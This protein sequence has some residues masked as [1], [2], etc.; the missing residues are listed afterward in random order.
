MH[1]FQD[2]RR[3]APTGTEADIHSQRRK[4]RALAA[5]R[6]AVVVGL[7]SLALAIALFA[8]AVPARAIV[9]NVRGHGYGITP[10]NGAAEA[11][12]VAAYRAEQAAAGHA[13]ARGFDE[14][15][16]GGSPLESKGGPVMHSA[17]THVIY[18]DPPTSQFTPT[19]RGI[20]D[21]FFTNVADDSGLP[22]NV[23]PIAGQYTDSTGH[24]AYSS[25]FEGALIDTHEY[26]TTGNC[27]VPNE[28]DNGPYA[29]CL[30]D[31][32]LREELSTVI[33]EHGL[34]KG[35]TQLYFVLLPH[36]VATCVERVI[37]GKQV[38]S[39]NFFCAY[40]SYIS[41]GTPNEIIYADIPFS[42]LDATFAKGCQAD[43]N[44]EIQLPNGDKGTSDTETRFA[45]VALKYL[46]H[47]Y[48]EAVTDPLVNF[49]T[50]WVDE[51]G[52]EIGDKCNITP[53]GPT[54]EGQSEF[55]KHA[56]TPTLGGNA[57]EGT[58]FNQTIN[59]G[60]YYLQ[61]EWDNGGRACLMKPLA[62]SGAAFT[63]GT[64]TAGSPVSFSGSSSD[65][66]GGFDPSWTFGDGGTG[67]GASPTHTFATAGVYTVTMT[68]V[69][70]LTDST[71]PSTSHSVTVA[72]PPAPTQPP[73]SGSTTSTPPVVAA[74][75]IA[76][77]SAFTVTAGSFNAKTGVITLRATVADPGTFSWLA[78]FANGKFGAF[79]SANKCKAGFLRL[80]GRCRPAKIVYA[81]ASQSFA[82]AGAAGITLKPSSSAARALKNALKK[83]KA[84]LVSGTLS[85]QSSRG[86]SPVSRPFAIAVKLKK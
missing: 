5:G 35:P 48:I 33:G 38:C 14:P 86:G 2:V 61:S 56:F 8:G 41:P 1:R 39:N 83:G 82:S 84:L 73:A 31:E 40:H 29:K 42:F 49:N 4:V 28:G 59:T 16:F 72:P 20:V 80:A 34:P 66:Y 9:A 27:T 24:A 51:E 53:E 81:R 26:P 62:L 6:S 19:T 79:A 57:A 11:N 78:T 18:W 3:Y 70:A 17:T 71:G 13:S 32:Q 74:Q 46:S 21:S 36:N 22:T 30:F 52:A 54:E 50:A 85:F 68:P 55:D 44:L 10:I 58:L 12:L 25:T 37:K 43:A 7:C 23:F 75:T 65:P 60:N 63:S 15:P 45:D 64:A 47:E 69:D 67:T 77:N 76:P